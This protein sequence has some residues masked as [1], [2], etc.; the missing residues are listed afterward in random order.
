MKN[1]LELSANKHALK[2]FSERLSN[3]C[4]FF[5]FFGTLLGLVRENQPIE[6]DDDVDFY[7]NKKDYAFIKDLI[8]LMG[9]DVDFGS[10]PNNTEY[11][12]Q[13]CGQH[14]GFEIRV[15]FYFY[16]SG[17]DDNFIL[18]PWNFAGK[19]TCEATVLKIP[20]ALVFPIKTKYYDDYPVPM[21]QHEAV[22]C[23]FLYGLNW[24]LPAKKEKDYKV[25]V[26]GGR[27]IRFQPKVKKAIFSFRRQAGFKEAIL[28]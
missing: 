23:E 1:A 15:D 8:S 10:S 13:V 9:F 20:K 19:P 17:A 2:L 22:L 27:P 16:D 4:E 26:C 24:R 28:P 25:M 5:V 11:F 12:I 7:V 21:P 18:E 6:G 14:S 3:K